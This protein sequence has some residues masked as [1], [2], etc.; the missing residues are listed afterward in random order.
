MPWILNL[1]LFTDTF[2]S[3]HKCTIFCLLKNN[4]SSSSFNFLRILLTF[5]SQIHN[6]YSCLNFLNTHYLPGPCNS[7]SIVCQI[8]CDT[9]HVKLTDLSNFSVGFGVF[10]SS[11]HSDF[12][13]KAMHITESSPI[14]I[15]VVEFYFF[16]YLIIVKKKCP[17]FSFWKFCVSD[18]KCTKEWAAPA[19]LL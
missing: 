4:V 16:F 14:C 5:S 9:F 19:S 17:K 7:A 1:S 12:V 3:L 8:T 11:S 10:L 13:S 6:F 18:L 2:H 15:C